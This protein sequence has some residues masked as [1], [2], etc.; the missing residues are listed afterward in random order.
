MSMSSSDALRQ[1]GAIAGRYIVLEL[2]G[3][4]DAPTYRITL[5]DPDG[6]EAVCLDDFGRRLPFK[7]NRKELDWLID[8][9]LVYKER[10]EKSP[11]TY[12]YRL[13]DEGRVASAALR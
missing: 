6:D 2:L 5:M 10:A 9:H 13:T 12:V 11:D 7:L 1:I 3:L 8:R 4:V